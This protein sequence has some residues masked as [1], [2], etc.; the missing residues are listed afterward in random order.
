MSGLK[1]KETGARLSHFPLGLER[2]YDANFYNGLLSEHMVR[3]NNGKWVWE[4]IPGHE[5]NEPLDCRNYANAAFY[6]LKPNLDSIRQ[7]LS[8]PV[9][10]KVKQPPKPRRPRR[11]VYEDW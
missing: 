2:G 8:R 3:Q 11:Q 9:E 6:V 5:R 1:V 10:E 4:K 7:S